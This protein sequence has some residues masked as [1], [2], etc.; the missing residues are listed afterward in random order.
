[1]LYHLFELDPPWFLTGDTL[2]TVFSYQLGMDEVVRPRGPA[3][4]SL[5]RMVTRIHIDKV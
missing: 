3:R 4:E 1:M 2:P 5:Q